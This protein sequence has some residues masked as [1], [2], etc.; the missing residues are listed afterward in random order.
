M[1]ENIPF[2]KKPKKQEDHEDD[3]GDW[4]YEN[5]AE[6]QRKDL[7][8]LIKTETTRGLVAA[9]EKLNHL[10]SEEI[11]ETITTSENAQEIAVS[12]YSMEREGSITQK[13][14]DTFWETV[15]IRYVDRSKTFSRVFMIAYFNEYYGRSWVEGVVK[16][17]VKY[18]DAAEWFVDEVEKIRR[19]GEKEG[20]PWIDEAEQIAFTTMQ[21]TFNL[22]ERH[23][24][25]FV[26]AYDT[27]SL[28]DHYG[29]EGRYAFA[30]AA[31]QNPFAA[32][33]FTETIRQAKT[34][35]QEESEYAPDNWSLNENWIYESRIDELL[36]KAQ[37]TKETFEK[38]VA[39]NPSVAMTVM[40]RLQEYQREE[41]PAVVPEFIEKAVEHYASAETFIEE[42]NKAECRWKN[43]EWTK[44]Y[45]EKAKALRNSVAQEAKERWNTILEKE[46]Q[47]TLSKEEFNGYFGSEEI[48]QAETG[49][50]YAVSAIYAMRKWS[51]FEMIARKSMKRNPD[52]SWE[53]RLPFMNEQG[54]TVIVTQEEIQPQKNNNFGKKHPLRNE[55]DTREAI[56]PIKGPEGYQVLEAAYLK[57]EFGVVDRA[58]SDKGGAPEEVLTIFGGDMFSV[59]RIIKLP[60]IKEG[61][62]INFFENFNPDVYIATCSGFQ[63]KEDDDRKKIEE[64]IVA[65][66]K[67]N[68]SQIKDIEIYMEHAYAIIGI[69][70]EA[71]MIG[72]VNPHDTKEVIVLT[73]EQFTE[74]FDGISTI[75]VNNE[76]LLKA[77]EREEKQVPYRYATQ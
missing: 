39:G 50:C 14:V 63:K 64:V 71:K 15:G 1:Q 49:N 38:T 56:D 9:V 32:H 76:K 25:H 47:F 70:T 42:T 31:I 52:G 17:A 3:E 60:S 57:K 43:Q 6:T 37:K 61:S 51:Q 45:I 53:V 21:Y 30:E 16:K 41:W 68:T 13:T 2:F 5:L 34:Y 74:L 62:F 33:A 4:L 72:I 29:E 27:H 19:L 8:H 46:E 58:K 18:F 36:E 77:A 28:Y 48:Q 22:N 55:I 67:E 59:S 44:K 66:E 23:A 40:K 75:R 54:E 12:L 7:Q 26:R 35:G 10:S 11:F 24:I 20:E 65:R 73:L 69:D